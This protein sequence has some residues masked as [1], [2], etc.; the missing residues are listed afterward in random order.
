[1]LTQMAIIL[2]IITAE[3]LLAVFGAYCNG[4][5]SRDRVSLRAQV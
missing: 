4:I 3:L 1:M 2:I 5:R